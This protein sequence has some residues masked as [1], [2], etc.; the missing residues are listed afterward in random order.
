M[1]WPATAAT[2]DTRSTMILLD[3]PYHAR[4]T[5]RAMFRL[6]LSFGKITNAP[7]DFFS[8]AGALPIFFAAILDISPDTVMQHINSKNMSKLIAALNE[9]LERDCVKPSENTDNANS[10]K[11]INWDELY[12]HARYRLNMSDDEFWSCTPR[13]FSVL[14]ELYAKYTIGTNGGPASENNPQAFIN[15]LGM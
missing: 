9:M 7:V 4:I 3:K 8:S 11:E 13:K 6:E 5:I 10:E 15:A 1:Q 2:L 14:S 12:H